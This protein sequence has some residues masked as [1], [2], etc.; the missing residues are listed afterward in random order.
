MRPKDAEKMVN[1]VKS[2]LIRVDTAS[3]DVYVRK[4]KIFTVQRPGK[5]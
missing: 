3:S 2:S 5:F 1:S 4:L